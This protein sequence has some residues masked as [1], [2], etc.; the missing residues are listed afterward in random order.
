[1]ELG[2]KLRQARLEAGLSQ[3]QLCAEEI[4]RNMLSQIEHGAA[5]PSMKTLQY[6]ASRLGK[7]VGYFLDEEAAASP[8][9]DLMESARRLYDSA[10]YAAAALVLEGYQGPDPIF[11]REKSLLWVLCHL[12]LAE[13]AIAE[14]RTAF[15]KIKLDKAAVET[16][17][18]SEELRRR[19]LLLLG[20]IQTGA[21][22]Q[23]PS[24]DEELLLRGEYALSTGEPERA[25][26]LLES[27]QRQEHPR[28]LLLRGRASLGMGDYREAARY[29]H[30]AESA[31][32]KETTAYLEQCYRELGDYKRAYEYAC[33]QKGKP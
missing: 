24:L 12:A 7:S 14:G 30:Q 27:V 19:R 13:L 9:Q 2:E 26:H 15:A 17:Y 6:L 4:T 16:A 11:D 32:P 8:N 25:L 10:D 18:C 20:R 22:A 28:W 5:R 29:F 21:C 23:L 31:F 33:K 3:R 1:M